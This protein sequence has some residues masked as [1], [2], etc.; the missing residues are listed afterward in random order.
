MLEKN[1]L[2]SSGGIGSWGWPTCQ[3]VQLYA[4][5]H[6]PQKAHTVAT[7]MHMQATLSGAFY[8]MQHLL[9]CIINRLRVIATYL[10][11]QAAIKRGSKAKR[12]IAAFFFAISGAYIRAR[13][14]KNGVDLQWA[15][16]PRPILALAWALLTV[17]I[18][19]PFHRQAAMHPVPPLPCTFV[20]LYPCTG[21][22]YMQ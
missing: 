18:L 17:A 4:Q 12:V 22:S 3:H 15:T 13:R 11:V 1:A 10:Q 7:N 14:V 20:P 2:M 5:D 8:A 19:A 21:V 6:L 9:C 16:K